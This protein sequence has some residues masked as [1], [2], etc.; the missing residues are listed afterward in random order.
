MSYCETGK[1]DIETLRGKKRKK[2]KIES[3]SEKGSARER[4]GKKERGM[5]EVSLWMWSLNTVKCCDCC[6]HP[7]NGKSMM[8][9]ALRWSQGCYIKAEVLHQR[10]AGSKYRSLFAFVGR[11]A[12]LSIYYCSI[13]PWQGS[14]SGALISLY[15]LESSTPGQSSCGIHRSLALK[16][17]DKNTSIDLSGV[18]HCIMPV[19]LL[20][21]Y[22]FF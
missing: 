5:T 13:K 2:S 8:G 17:S 12:S 21:L 10:F 22:L 14:R 6:E 18:D 16:V 9:R 4:D 7:S 1:R 20:L 3:V 11:Q 15:P 19:N